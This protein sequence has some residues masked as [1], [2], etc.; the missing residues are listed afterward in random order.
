VLERRGLS[1]RKEAHRGYRKE[2]TLTALVIRK[3]WA[4][5]GERDQSRNLE[6]STRSLIPKKRKRRTLEKG[7]SPF[8][9]A[10]GAGL[11]AGLKGGGRTQKKKDPKDRGSKKKDRHQAK[12]SVQSSPFENRNSK[13]AKGGALAS[14]VAEVDGKERRH[15]EEGKGRQDKKQKAEGERQT[16]LGSEIKE[17]D[18]LHSVWEGGGIV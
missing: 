1:K 8:R 9:D 18:E 11:G 2:S 16:D 12:K 17:R 15:P 14:A 13:D 6:A 3:H 7:E 4:N 10:C 5:G